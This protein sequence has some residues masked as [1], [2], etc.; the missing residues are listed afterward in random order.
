[1]ASLYSAL[2][3]CVCSS[4][5]LHSHVAKYYATTAYAS[6][7]NSKRT[8]LIT[9]FYALPITFT[10]ELLNLQW[11][12]T[13]DTTPE[14]WKK[15]RRICQSR[16]EDPLTT[17]ECHLDPIQRPDKSLGRRVVRMGTARQPAPAP[18]QNLKRANRDPRVARQPL[19]TQ[20][21]RLKLNLHNLNKI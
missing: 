3:V 13:E 17:H 19:R 15:P 8:D 16:V 5:L 6:C 14:A 18:R 11:E 12:R 2:F 4:L 21:K 1:M 9:D 20:R 7:E 10:H